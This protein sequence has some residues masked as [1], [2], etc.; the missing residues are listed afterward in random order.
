MPEI[1]DIKIFKKYLISVFLKYFANIAVRV[2]FLAI[3]SGYSDFARYSDLMANDP[4]PESR[5]KEISSRRDWGR[6]PIIIA[7]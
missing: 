3:S 6:Q 4:S 1:S 5:P 2:I 7:A